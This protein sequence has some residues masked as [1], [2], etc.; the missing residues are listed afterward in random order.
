MQFTSSLITGVLV[1]ARLASGLA[2]Q[3]AFTPH[4]CDGRASSPRLVCG[5]VTV[6]ETPGAAGGRSIPLNVVVVRAAHPR[7]GAPPLFHLEGGPGL[8]A[9]SAAG[10]Y[11]GPGAGYSEP[12]D[13]VLVDQRGTGGSA[14][15]PLRCDRAAPGLGGRVHRGGRRRVQ[16]RTLRTRRSDAIHHRA[17]GAR[18]RPCE[19]GAG[20]PIIDIWALS[21]GT[22]L[23]QVYLKRFPSRV[24]AAVLVGFAPLDYRTPLFHAV[25]AQRVLD[26]I[27]TSASATRRARSATRNCARTGRP[28]CAALTAVRFG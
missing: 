13:V 5:T 24:H 23:A 12:R 9:S 16:P 17:G 19:G 7:Q 8:G 3:P 2:A 20:G 15:S 14:A 4:P 18:S 25:N 27:S 10:F 11:L 6:A 1:T 21:Y 28:S 26:L 22:R